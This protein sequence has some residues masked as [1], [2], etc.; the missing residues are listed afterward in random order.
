MGS[1][2]SKT[3]LADQPAKT[4]APRRK[5]R[6]LSEVVITIEDDKKD[7][8][9]FTRS[10]SKRQNQAFPAEDDN[11]LETP[12]QGG[13]PRPKR[14]RLSPPIGSRMTLRP[15]LLSL[16]SV[17]PCQPPR[18]REAPPDPYFPHL[19]WIRG[20]DYWS[21]QDEADLQLDH[22]EW[23]RQMAW[24]APSPNVEQQIW[25]LMIKLFGRLPEDL[26]R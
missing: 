16:R 20:E 24:A 21:E 8:G 18:C 23:A 9:Y 14:R 2:Q 12:N 25:R 17:W 26:F 19:D 7:T 22:L 10:Q 5:K 13:T 15:R 3:Q 4:V 11:A 6:P 1:T